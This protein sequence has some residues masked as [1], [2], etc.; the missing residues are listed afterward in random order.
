MAEKDF[1]GMLN[2]IA[3]ANRDRILATLKKHIRPEL[4][5][6][7]LV[8][9]WEHFLRSDTYQDVLMDVLYVLS[10][11]FDVKVFLDE[12]WRDYVHSRAWVPPL[13]ERNG[14]ADYDEFCDAVKWRQRAMAILQMWRGLV[15]HGWL[16]NGEM[17]P[18]QG[19]IAHDI[20]AQLDAVEPI[21]KACEIMFEELGVAVKLFGATECTRDWVHPMRAR[22]VNFPPAVRFKV[23]DLY[24]IL[25]IEKK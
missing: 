14:A 22:A 3:P 12:K 21:Y 16:P 11:Q 4:D 8:T 5:R 20:D 25:H 18:L 6:M 23:Y 24:D 1:L 9:L 7:Y 10:G 13:V 15:D 17:V 2:K 19:A